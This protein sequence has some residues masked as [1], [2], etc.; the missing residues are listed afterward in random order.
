MQSAKGVPM[1]KQADKRDKSAPQLIELLN[2]ALQMEYTLIVHY[3]R[4]A[5]DI[6]DD[7]ARALAFKLGTDSVRHADIV[8]KTITALGG[9]PAWSFAPLPD[10]I[11]LL[12]IFKTQLNK[13]KAAFTLYEDAAT[14]T[15]SRSLADSFTAIANEELRHIE[16][17]ELIIKKI[18]LAK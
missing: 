5:G 12:S 18:T 14:L 7:E 17:V 9:Q 10:Y 13:E 4:L 3:P 15:S 8:S 11:D 1:A 16:M 2:T 6:Q